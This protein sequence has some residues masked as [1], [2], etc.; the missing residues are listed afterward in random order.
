VR[1]APSRMYSRL[2]DDMLVFARSLRLHQTDAENLLW[3]LLR[4][5][6]L[7]FKFRRQHPIGRFI[8]DFYCQ[9]ALLAVELDG[10][11]HND[12]F[13]TL[14]DDRRSEALAK[15]GIHVLRFWNHEVLSST[16]AVLEKI[17]Q[18]LMQRT[19]GPHPCPSPKGRGGIDL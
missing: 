16:E 14:K 12:D 5:R 7:G 4:R 8:L 18:E 10:G 2:S 17:Y 19:G 9:E 1:E 6:S 3:L 11:E 15:A 13:A